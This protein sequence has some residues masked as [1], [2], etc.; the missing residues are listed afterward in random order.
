MT[1]ANRTWVA[2]ADSQRAH[3]V[4][5][6]SAPVDR[7]HVEHCDSITFDWVGHEHG[8]PSPRTGRNGKT[9]ASAGHEDAENLRRFARQVA[10]WLAETVDRYEIDRLVLFAPARFLGALRKSWNGRL[11]D[12]IEEHEGDLTGAPLSTL[13][14]H[15]A[16]RNLVED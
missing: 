10:N 14:K 8:R 15:P 3:L 7:C 4:Q 2:L 1:L 6:S 12:R 5:A 16:I 11:S 9:Y 13:S